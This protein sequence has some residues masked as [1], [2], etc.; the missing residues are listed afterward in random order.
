MRRSML[1][2]SGFITF[3]AIEVFSGLNALI[4]GRLA[5]LPHPL[6]TRQLVVFL[7]IM[8]VSVGFLGAFVGFLFG[9]FQRFIPPM[10]SGHQ[11]AIFFLLVA[12][13]TSALKGTTYLLSIDFLITAV[14]S[15]VGGYV[16]IWL[17]D[18]MTS[19]E[20]DK[21]KAEPPG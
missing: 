7:V 1:A 6:T 16:F 8:T 13:L 12:A 5:D 3:A 19:R 15:I 18:R 9:V 17:Y 10:K 14:S 21:T 11:A 20:D 2:L 4:S